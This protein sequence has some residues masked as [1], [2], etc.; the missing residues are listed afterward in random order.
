MKTHQQS[1]NQCE[2]LIEGGR[3]SNPAQYR[4]SH[5]HLCRECRQRPAYR[6]EA[7]VLPGGTI[8]T[9]P[10]REVEE[11]EAMRILSLGAGVQSTALALMSR[12]GMFDLSVDAAVFADTQWEPKAVYRHLAWLVGE[13]GE[14]LPVYR[15]S[16]GDIRA[17]YV[18]S[19]ERPGERNDSPLTLG[20]LEARDGR[21]VDVGQIVLPRARASKRIASMPFHVRNPE[22]E[23]AMLRRQC[24]REYKIEPIR[25]ALRHLTGRK[26]RQRKGETTV[27][28]WI[29]ISLDE[30]HRMGSSDTPW[31]THR[32][33]LVE[34]RLTRRD[35]LE[36]LALRGYPEPTKSSCV[37][38]PFHDN[39]YWRQVRD[40]APD[41]WADAVDF[42]VTIRNLSEQG[43]DCDAFLHRQLVPLDQAD[44]R[45]KAEQLMDAGQLPLVLEMPEL[46]EVTCDTQHCFT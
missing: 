26:P 17:D 23:P 30:W 21:L 46:S 32:Y 31:I 44:L 41:E 22:G 27:E 2:A 16:I 11:H 33:P 34:K 43:V 35:C 38:C 40:H 39:R 15:V 3:C 45:T 18:R 1:L 6:L 8:E 36:W 4:R 12:D 29:G 25:A 7:R 37:G 20:R 19:V 24:T 13:L 9:A 5:W 14:A 28:Q 42:D 10:K